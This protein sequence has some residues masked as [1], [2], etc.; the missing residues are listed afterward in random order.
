MY[1]LI[2]Q[3]MDRIVRQSGKDYDKKKD[4]V[5]QYDRLIEGRKS[6]LA[7][8]YKRDY[9]SFWVM[10]RA[11]FSPEFYDAFFNLLAEGLRQGER[12]SFDIREVLQRLYDAPNNRK[13]LQFSFAT[14][15]LHTIDPTLPV[16]DLMI[17]YF[18]FLDLPKTSLALSDRIDALADLHSFLIREYARVLRENLLTPAI[19]AFRETYQPKHFTDEKI[20]DTLIWSFVGLRFSDPKFNYELQY[21]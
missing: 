11:V 10:N 21:T 20:I 12:R 9:R 8:D 3:S 5:K 19:S 15:L 2:N 4:Y 7:E 16:Y 17:A 1:K 14:K 13:S 6:K 18:Y